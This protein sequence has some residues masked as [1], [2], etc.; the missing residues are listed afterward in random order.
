MWSSWRPRW[1]LSCT[2]SR[3]MDAARRKLTHYPGLAPMPRSD[4]RVSAGGAVKPFRSSR[5]R[6]PRARVS[7]FTR[8]AWYPAAAHRSSFALR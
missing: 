4:E 2:A 5:S 1:F 3:P 7:T 8:R 6:E